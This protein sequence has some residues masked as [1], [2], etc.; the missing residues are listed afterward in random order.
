[1]IIIC[2]YWDQ[3]SEAV[4]LDTLICYYWD[5]R[6]EAVDLDTA[7]YRLLHVLTLLNGL[8]LLYGFRVT[9]YLNFIARQLYTQNSPKFRK[10]QYWSTV[11]GAERNNLYIMCAS[12]KTCRKSVNKV[13]LFYK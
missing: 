7:L 2:Y 12:F 3:R 5:Q 1:M 8:L 13:I 6:S 9:Y 10:I 11:R 4:D